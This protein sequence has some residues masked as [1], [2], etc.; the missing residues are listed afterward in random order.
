MLTRPLAAGSQMHPDRLELM[1]PERD[2]LK[3]NSNNQKG[4]FQLVFPGD[5]LAVRR[6]LKKAMEFLRGLDFSQDS[7]GPIE[8]V[9]AEAINNVIEHAYAGHSHGVVELSIELSG[10]DLF[11]TILDDGLPMPDNRA[12]KGQEHDLSCEVVDLPEGGFGWFLIRELTRDLIYTRTGSRN[13]LQF[14]IRPYA[15]TLPQ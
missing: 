15:G 14:T 7:C 8:L 13:R 5:Q 10:K 4:R 11:F 9:L 1:A 2:Y 12:P 6:T 3:V